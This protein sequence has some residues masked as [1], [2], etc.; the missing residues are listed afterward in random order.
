M[1]ETYGQMVETREEVMW[2]KKEAAMDDGRTVEDSGGRGVVA[3]EEEDGGQGL[4]VVVTE[5]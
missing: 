5:E 2:G 4:K 1:E 3:L